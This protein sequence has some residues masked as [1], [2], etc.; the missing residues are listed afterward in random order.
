[1]NIYIVI[2]FYNEVKHISKVANEAVGYNIPVVLV[3]DGSSD[4]SSGKISKKKNLVLLTHKTNLGKGAAM[5]TGADYSFSKGADA[6][7]FM[8]GDA[9]HKSE[10]IN[11]FIKILNDGKFDAVFGSRNFSYGVPLVR[12]LGNKFASLLLNLMFG[13]Y[14]SDVL[15]GFKALTKKGYKLMRWDSSG[16]G[17]ETEMVARAGK[18]KASFCEV[19]VETIYHDKVKGVTILD[20]FGIMIEIVKWRATIK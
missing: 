20:A 13:I 18:N 16:Y 7:I 15:C 2:P 9:Q 17:V 3:D 5:K 10:D 4:G 12:Y 19:P 6:V 1:M 8:D 11:K 14:V